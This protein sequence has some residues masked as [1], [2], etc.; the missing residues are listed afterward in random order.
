MKA[1]F[2]AAVRLSLCAHKQIFNNTPDMQGRIIECLHNNSSNFQLLFAFGNYLLWSECWQSIVQWLCCKR[3]MHKHARMWDMAVEQAENAGFI[4]SRAVGQIELIIE[5]QMLS[6]KAAEQFTDTCAP[7]IRTWGCHMMSGAIIQGMSLT[8]THDHIH[9]DVIRDDDQSF[10]AGPGS[11]ST[12]RGWMKK[13][14]L[15]LIYVWTSCW[16]ILN[17]GLLLCIALNWDKLRNMNWWYSR[18]ASFKQ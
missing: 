11:N 2:P 6:W 13:K 4:K 16:Y 15:T 5:M 7:E 17:T 18:I 3:A 10:S 9:Q 12:K 14:L 8:R 1:P